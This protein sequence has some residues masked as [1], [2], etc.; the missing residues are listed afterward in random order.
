MQIFHIATA[1]NWN[2]AK[3]TGNYTTST[4]GRSL[5]EEGFIHAARRDQVRGVLDR[6]YADI[7]EPL[8]I[9]QIETDRLDAEVREE[10]PDPAQPRVKF[11][12][13]YGPIPVTAVS[14]VVALKRDNRLP[15]GLELWMGEAMKR[16]AWAVFAMCMAFGGARLG[17]ARLADHGALIGAVG[18]LLLGALL[19]WLVV[20]RPR[21]G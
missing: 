5:A 4:R 18:G 2:Q 3:R 15:G 7:S 17:E 19:A 1:A 10:A 14:N 8:V 6:Y 21:S 13:V 11:P 9:L 20:R 12:H 16:I